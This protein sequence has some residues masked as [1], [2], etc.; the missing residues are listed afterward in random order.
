LTAIDGAEEY[1]QYFLALA[2]TQQGKRQSSAANQLFQ[3]LAESPNETIRAAS[4]LALGLRAYRAKDYKEARFLIRQACELADRCGKALIT[5][6]MCRTSLAAI[7]SDLGNYRA[8]VSIMQE[9]LP[10][11]FL[12][13]QRIPAYL[14]I[15]LNNYACD[16]SRINKLEYA[17]K[18]ITMAVNSPYS[19]MYPEWE[20][21]KNEIEAK[22][23]NVTGIAEYRN[24]KRKL[25]DSS[26]DDT[27]LDVYTKRRQSRHIFGQIGLAETDSASKLKIDNYFDGLEQIDSICEGEFIS[28]ES[29]LCTNG[30]RGLINSKDIAEE[31]LPELE[32]LI[33]ESN[34]ITASASVTG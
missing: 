5:S 18:T 20:E 12:I 25:T 2:Q 16:L 7:H 28:V 29:Y 32:T 8:S 15:E 14:G 23:N 6:T 27:R 31:S 19:K 10:S 9:S 26:R 30:N 21:T 3:Q 11:I 33:T 34:S 13:G 1:G 17:A 24:A 22:L 4:M